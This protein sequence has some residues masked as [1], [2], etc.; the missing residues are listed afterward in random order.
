MYVA[1]T[2]NGFIKPKIQQLRSQLQWFDVIYVNI[3]CIRPEKLL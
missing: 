3:C 1:G 2:V